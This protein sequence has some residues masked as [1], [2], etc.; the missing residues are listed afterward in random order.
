[1]GSSGDGSWQRLRR[2]GLA[3]MLASA[4]GLVAACGS[5][6][7][8]TGLQVKQALESG[9]AGCE[10]ITV[11]DNPKY[12]PDLTF[13]VICD[14]TDSNGG[15]YVTFAKYKPGRFHGHCTGADLDDVIVTDRENFSVT[16]RDGDWPDELHAEDVQRILGGEIVTRSELCGG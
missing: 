8:D 9:G 5:P 13:G 7:Y 1:M 6:T 10:S 14:L 15:P 2:A 16:G 11:T 3:V 12:A 4:A